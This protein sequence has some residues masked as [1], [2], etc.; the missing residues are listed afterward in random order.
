MR[1]QNWLVRLSRK[2]AF[3]QLVL[4]SQS[5]LARAVWSSCDDPHPQLRH[6]TMA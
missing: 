1:T 2:H 3:Q 4:L 5:Q 6:A